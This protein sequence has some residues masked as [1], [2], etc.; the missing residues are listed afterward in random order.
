MRLTWK[1]GVATVL[2]AA[3]VV[4]G[5][6]VAGDWGWPLLGSPRAGALAAGFIG[7]AMCSLSQ[8]GKDMEDG[9][10]EPA[11]KVLAALGMLSLV[12]MIGGVIINSELMFLGLLIVTIG[13]WLMSTIRHAA[14]TGSTR[15]AAHPA[16]T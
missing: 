12:L 5:L 4:V 14:G 7:I 8:A 3:V 15:R 10:R 9:L 6:A 16:R 1:D 11:A 2:A 13:M